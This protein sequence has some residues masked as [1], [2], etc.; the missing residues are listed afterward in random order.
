MKVYY[1]TDIKFVSNPGVR[2]AGVNRVFLSPEEAMDT[3]ESLPAPPISLC[4]LCWE[5]SD[6][7]LL[8]LINNEANIKECLVGLG[9]NSKEKISLIGIVERTLTLKIENNETESDERLEQ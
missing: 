8:S 4:L 3:L 7:N 6:E 5:L 9:S 2:I 1:F